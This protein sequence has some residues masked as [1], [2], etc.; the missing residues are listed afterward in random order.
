MADERDLYYCYRLLLDRDP[1][2]MG[3]RHYE[4]EVR[5]GWSVRDLVHSFMTSPEFQQR[6]PIPVDASEHEDVHA[7]A[8]FDIYVNSRD[9]SSGARFTTPAPTSLTSRV[10]WQGI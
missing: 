9:W 7:G 1:D 6:Q 3:W 2:K 4:N 5:R 10:F 8:G